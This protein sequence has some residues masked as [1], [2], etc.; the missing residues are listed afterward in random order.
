[1]PHPFENKLV[2]FIGNPI[3][4]TRQEAR[5]ALDEVGG[6]PDERITTFTHY[7]VAFSGAERTKVYQKA[8]GHDKYGH[9]ILLNE[10]QF[11]DI[12]EGNAEP[13]KKKTPPPMPGVIVFPAK[14]PEAN[15]RDSDRVT[16]YVVAKKRLKNMARYGTPSPDGGR[17]KVDFRLFDMVK[18][19]MKSN[20]DKTV[21]LGSDSVDRCDSCGKPSRVHIGDGAGNDVAKLCLNCHNELM[22]KLTDTEMPP[23]VPNR[24]SFQNNAGETRDFDIEF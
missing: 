8:V 10:K 13:P 7:V 11:F 12:L 18:Q 16:Q 9:M 4:C 6:V 5:D 17:I 22:A 20:A 14:N 19:L 15:E 21:I 23:N 3:R 24:L 1:M 2:V